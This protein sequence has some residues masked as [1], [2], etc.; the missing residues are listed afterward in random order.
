MRRVIHGS[1][2][3]NGNILP[4]ECPVTSTVNIIWSETS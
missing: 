3:V 1:A 4:S 2:T